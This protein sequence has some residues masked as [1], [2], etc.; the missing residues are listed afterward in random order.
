MQ[1]L[2]MVPGTEALFDNLHVGT[3]PPSSD[4]FVEFFIV[5]LII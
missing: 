2:K 1:D 5:F 3:Q 4:V